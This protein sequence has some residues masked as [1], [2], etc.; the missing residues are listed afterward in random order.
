[1]PLSFFFPLSISIPRCCSIPLL[2]LASFFH[3]PRHPPCISPSAFRP[4]FLPFYNYI[5]YSLRIA[6]ARGDS[7]CETRNRPTDRSEG[8]IKTI[9]TNAVAEE[10]GAGT[11]EYN[12]HHAGEQQGGS[13]HPFG[14]PFLCFSCRASWLTQLQAKNFRGLRKYWYWYSMSIKILLIG[15]L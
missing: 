3:G 6:A 1:M 2:P 14:L 7:C 11:F 4:R 15:C 8:K 9:A 12:E 10:L 13:F 5:A